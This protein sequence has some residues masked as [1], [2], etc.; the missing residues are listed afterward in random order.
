[1]ALII[2]FIDRAP[3]VYSKKY[4][5]RTQ[6]CSHRFMIRGI[7][8]Q[9]LFLYKVLSAVS[10]L[11]PYLW[12]GSKARCRGKA[13][14]TWLNNLDQ[15]RVKGKWKTPEKSY[16]LEATLHAH[17]KQW[18]KA[19]S[20]SHAWTII[21]GSM[22]RWKVGRNLRDLN[23]ELILLLMSCV[24]LSKFQDFYPPGSSYL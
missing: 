1:M 14:S 21:K 2:H 16:Q 8:T 15:K 9:V 12:A 6:E 3:K 19:F 7:W 10:L 4:S 24:T 17:E 18:G 11:H 13:V 20:R 22:G 23:S 5:A